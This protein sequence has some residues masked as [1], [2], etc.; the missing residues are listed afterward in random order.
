[1]LVASLMVSDLRIPEIKHAWSCYIIL[2]IHCW[3]LFASTVVRIF[4]SIFV[5]EIR[6]SFIFFFSGFG[7]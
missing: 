3:V 7:I 5:S 6:L 4:A 2:L 1:M